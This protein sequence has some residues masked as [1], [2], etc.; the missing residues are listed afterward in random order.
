VR[1][2]FIEHHADAATLTRRNIPATLFASLCF[3]LHFRRNLTLAARYAASYAL[4]RQPSLA[5]RL[6]SLLEKVRN[7]WNPPR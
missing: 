2:A 5:F 3:N 4:L 7:R 6:P 1:G